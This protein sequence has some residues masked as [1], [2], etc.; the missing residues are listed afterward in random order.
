[1][2]GSGRGDQPPKRRADNSAKEQ[3]QFG[4]VAALDGDFRPLPQSNQSP[5]ERFGTVYP[6][7]RLRPDLIAAQRSKQGM[8]GRNVANSNWR[9]TNDHPLDEGGFDALDS[10]A[11]GAEPLPAYDDGSRGG[12]DPE[13][14]RPFASQHVEKRFDRICVDCR[15]GRCVDGGGR[16]RVP[17]SESDQIFIRLFSGAEPLAKPRD[18]ALLES[19][20]LPHVRKNSPLVVKFL[21]PRTL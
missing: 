12:V 2:T 21:W 20:R 10:V 3:Q 5:R 1:M 9:Q 7:E 14:K 4:A 19:N 16:S 6:D 13:N 8:T 18:G 17:T 15:Q 11:I